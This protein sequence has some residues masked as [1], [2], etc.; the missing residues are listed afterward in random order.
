MEANTTNPSNP[1]PA[2]VFCPENVY[3]HFMSAAYIQVHFR[4]DVFMEAITMKP[5]KPY[6]PNIVFGLKMLSAAFY[7]CCM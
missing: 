4:L 1:Y 3:L 7:I 6:P 5:G 2:T